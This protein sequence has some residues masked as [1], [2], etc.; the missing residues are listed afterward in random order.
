MVY[1][2]GCFISY[3]SFTRKSE[4]YSFS[5]ISAY[6]KRKRKMHDPAV[7]NYPR[8]EIARDTAAP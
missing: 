4:G 3:V 1:F 7:A 2:R 8:R 5:I 6:L